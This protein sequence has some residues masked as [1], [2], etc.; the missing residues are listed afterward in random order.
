MVGLL[1][2]SLALLLHGGQ[3]SRPEFV[4][5]LDVTSGVAGSCGRYDN[6]AEERRDT[7]CDDKGWWKEAQ[8]EQQLC[9]HCRTISSSFTCERICANP[10][11]P[12]S[13]VMCDCNNDRG[14]KE[15]FKNTVRVKCEKWCVNDMEACSSEDALAESGALP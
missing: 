7:I 15:D 8:G 14:K 2:G 12:V 11:P 9:C 1:V 3:A 13:R 10:L 5:D 4:L 6:V